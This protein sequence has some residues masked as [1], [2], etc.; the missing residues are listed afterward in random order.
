MSMYIEGTQ[1]ERGCGGD[2][3]R[4]CPYQAILVD[5]HACVLDRGTRY[6]GFAADLWSLVDPDRGQKI[7][8][9]LEEAWTIDPDH[10][11]DEDPDPDRC[12]GPGQCRYLLNLID[13]L[14]E[15]LCD[16][17]DTKEDLHINKE[18]A[19]RI[20][21]NHPWLVTSWGEGEEQVHT[22]ANAVHEVGLLEEL[23]KMALKHGRNICI[24]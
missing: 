8:V 14:E 4:Q 16:E 11:Y 24:G 2:G 1:E 5:R 6:I 23:F 7:S 21:E 17:L 13:G 10:P 15:A 22:I 9:W 18:Q 20:A 3:C 19:A 12:Y